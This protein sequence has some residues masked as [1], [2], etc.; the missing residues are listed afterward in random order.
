[1]MAAGGPEIFPCRA[2]DGAGPEVF[3]KRGFPIAECRQCGTRFVP[4]GAAAPMRYDEG[5]F[6]GLDPG[7][8]YASYLADRDLVLANFD[9]RLRWLAGHA[10]GPRLL[11]V[12]AAYGFLLAAARRHGFEGIGV[13]PAAGCAEVAR[14]ELGVEVRTGTIEEIDLPAREFDV[15]T[16]LD[17][18]EHLENPRAALARIHSLLRPGGLLVVETG[19]LHGL[20]SRVSGQRWY[21]YDPPQHVTFFSQQSLVALLER[22]GFSAPVAVGAIGRE[23]SLRNFAYQLGRALGDGPSGNLSRSIARSPLGRIR[24]HVPDRGNAFVVAVRRLGDG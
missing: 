7:G 20:L 16:M 14:R 15:A 6:A 2:C 8:G 9:R 21:F 17:V 18:V 3:R 23:V 10:S 24:F 11:D 1:M 22:A 13:E 12:G 4:R 5:Y 19:D